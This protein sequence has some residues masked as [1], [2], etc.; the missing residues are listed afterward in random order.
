MDAAA[1]PPRAR[2]VLCVGA[3]PRDPAAAERR[4]GGRCCVA[5]ETPID[6]RDLDANRPDEVR[7]VGPACPCALALGRALEDYICRRPC[8]ALLPVRRE[9]SGAL[10]RLREPARCCACCL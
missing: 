9:T 8:P 10:P 6:A 1:L 7:V 4:C 3:V 2:A 5:A